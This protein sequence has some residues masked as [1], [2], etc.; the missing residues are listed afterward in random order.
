MSLTYPSRRFRPHM[1]TSLVS[2]HPISLRIN[3]LSTTK[4]LSSWSLR[5][6]KVI[7]VSGNLSWN[8]FQRQMK[9][10]R[11][12]HRLSRGILNA[13]C[14]CRMKCKGKMTQFLIDWQRTEHNLRKTNFASKHSSKP[15]FKRLIQWLAPRMRWRRWWPCGNGRGW[16]WTLD[17]LA[18]TSYRM[19]LLCVPWLTLL[20]IV[21]SRNKSGYSSTLK[22]SIKT[23]I[24][25][26]N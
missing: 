6:W 19:R 14:H 24:S 5:S 13:V 15:T 22:K 23:C 16:T 17:A 20:I 4:S 11:L 25:C 26:S 9:H 1:L 10:S 12:S 21:Q 7:R 8:I 2:W 3:G 18:F